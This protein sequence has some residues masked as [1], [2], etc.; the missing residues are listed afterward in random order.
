MPWTAVCAA[1]SWSDSMIVIT[2]VFAGILDMT[3]WGTPRFCPTSLIS[4][5]VSSVTTPLP[6]EMP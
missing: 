1:P 2:P 6:V 3:A 4:W 5:V